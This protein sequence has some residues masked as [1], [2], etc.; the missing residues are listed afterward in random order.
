MPAPLECRLLVDLP[1]PGAWN[2]AVD[3]LLL[4]WAAEYGRAALRFYLWSEPTLSLGY[5]QAA[6][7]RHAYSAGRFCPVVRRLTG[8]GALVHDRELTYSLVLPHDSALARGR[9]QLYS[10]VHQSLIAALADWE[11]LASAHAAPGDGPAENEPFL[12]FQRR[13]PGDILVGGM[14]IGGSA[15]RRRKG[16]VLQHGSVLLGRSAAAPELPGLLEL[17]GLEISPHRLADAWLPH[18][19]EMLDLRSVAEELSDGE[20]GRAEH[21]VAA[22]YSTTHWTDVRG[23]LSRFSRR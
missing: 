1:A 7:E 20:R 3:E 12:C 15:Q 16:A 5:F 6:S 10:L 11:I 8:G 22:R 13:S 2:M 14:K 21:L 4:D 9:D 18:L 17:T 19:T 23:G